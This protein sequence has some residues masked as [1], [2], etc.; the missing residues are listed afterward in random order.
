[1][2]IP[3]DPR[4]YDEVKRDIYERYPK[5]SAY[6]SGLLVKSYKAAYYLKHPDAY[7]RNDAYLSSKNQNEGLTRWFREEWKN[8]K[9]E[10]GY[11]NAA[12]V[13][14]PTKRITEQ[15]PL[16]F[17]ELTPQRIKRAQQEKKITGRVKR[18]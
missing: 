16:T 4:L 3:T 8:Q 6:R 7:N 2:V 18:F 11:S 12:D 1:M 10:T 15:T 17:N 9:G 5:H 13:Y 14:R